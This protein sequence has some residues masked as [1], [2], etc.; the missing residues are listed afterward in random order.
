M[1]ELHIKR[2]FWLSPFFFGLIIQLMLLDTA[3][4]QDAGEVVS[5]LGTVEVMRDGR[6]QTVNAGASLAAGDAVRTGAGSRAA[7]LLAS[8]TQIKLN[9]YSQLELKRIVPS[10]QGFIPA[11]SQAL[12]NILRLLGGEIWVRNSG[13]ALEVQT[14]PATA[15]IR[16]TEFTLAVRPDD[17]ARLAV[18]NGLVE[19][20]NPQGN[21]LV[22]ANEQAD[23]RLGEA[24]RKTV[25][26]NP[27]DAVQWSFYYLPLPP[28]PS[29]AGEGESRNK[30][31]SPLAGEGRGE[32]VSAAQR[33]LLAGQVD[34][35]RQALERALTLDPHNADAYSLRSN[36]ELVQNRRAEA[37]AD[38]ER[39]IAVNPAAPSAWLSLS[40]VQQAEFD[41]DGALNSARQAVALDPENPQALIQESSLLFGMGRLREAVKVAKRARQHAPDDAMV[42]TVWGFLQLAQNRVNPAGEA[43]EKAIAQDST[44]GLPHLGLGLVLFRRNQTDAA[45]VEM[46]KATLLEPLVSL[47]N[48]YL[49]KAFY[50]VKQDQRAQKYLEVAK[51]LDPRDPTPWLYDAIRLQSVNR[52]VEAVESLQKSIELNDQRGVYRSRLLLDEDQATRAA[53]LGRIYN[54]VG[55]TQLGLQQGWRSVNRDPANYSAHRL[56]ADSYAALPGIEAAR[57]S[58]LLQA[59]LLQPINITPVSLRMAETRLALPSA[60]PLSPSLYEFNP[61]F[62]R[63]KPS[64]YFSGAGGNQGA[65]GDELIVA[66]LTERFSYS[67]GQFH[68]QSD[69]Y[70]PNND[71]ENNLYNLFFQT[72]VTP[73]FNLQAEYRS[74]ETFS[75]DL[76]SRYDGSFRSFQ[77]TD[78]EQEMARVGARYVL[79]P[80][81]QLIASVVYTDRDFLKSFPNVN[82][83]LGQKIKGTQVET[84]LLYRQDAFNV[85]SG[86]SAYSIDYNEYDD[87]SDYPVTESTQKIAYSYANIKIPNN[88]IWTLGLS[89]ESDD[90]P[91]AR[92]NELNPKLGVQWAI[93]DQISL[94]AAAFQTVKR[95]FATR[96]TIEPTQV[97]GFNQIIDFIDLTVSKNYGVGLDVRFT[98]R[99]SGG[100]EALKRDNQVPFGVLDVPEF[101]FIE[102]NQETFYSAYLYW[103]PNHRWALSASWRYEEFEEKGCL[104]CQLFASIP[105][106]LQT[107]SLPLKIQYFDPSGFFA[108]WGMVYVNQDIQLIDPRSPP[109]APPTFLPTQN[110][111]FTLFDAGLGY[112]LSKRQG[113]ITLEVKNL[114]DRQFYF[115][116]YTFQTGGFVSPLYTP[117]RMFFG[118]LILNF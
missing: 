47:Y 67:L 14:I 27:L 13:E 15:T 81:T 61:L 109:G 46:R 10:H 3:L 23:V 8:G 40:W 35:A 110:E 7:I 63:E 95:E 36:I 117:E 57:A 111:E 28:T 11:A 4:A 68:Y 92:L 90:S 48:S 82:A 33:Y 103:V 66:G 102:P 114:F 6:W 64:L 24:P 18:V 5:A 31:P 9:A 100:L 79:S 59:Q 19:F 1:S 76:E 26:L 107:I 42:N 87:G 99:L 112:R 116:D 54:E 21:V 32:G 52:P 25:L 94:R 20:G 30:T 51:Q 89:Y 56:L 69:G 106:Q 22:A 70:R 86:L 12:D 29:H 39:A 71:L 44:L 62:V 108:G 113:I 41:L 75:G 93:N 98:D 53:T 16:G 38:A 88:V 43:F 77:R 34:A 50:E 55:F 118:R 45:I 60:G 58:E 97:A 101:Y 74:L 84:Q 37:R 72:A 83:F 78:V 2:Y 85:I 65:W 104:L 115:Q 96:Q 49:G 73:Q 91:Y 17:T 105:A 80:Q